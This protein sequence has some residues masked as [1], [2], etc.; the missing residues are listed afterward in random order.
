MKLLRAVQLAFAARAGDEVGV[1]RDLLPR[2]TPRQE[3]H[4][5]REVLELRDHLLYPHHDDVY[6]RNASYQPGVALVGDGA[7]SACLGDPEVGARNAYVRVQEFLRRAVRSTLPGLSPLS[8]AQG[9]RNLLRDGGLTRSPRSPCS[10]IWRGSSPHAAAPEPRRSGPRPRH[11]L[12]RT[13]FRPA[14]R[15]RR[16]SAKGSSRGSP[17]SPV[18]H[19]TPFPS[20]PA[21]RDG[22]STGR[23]V[24]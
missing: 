4:E 15:W 9:P 8:P 13:R 14:P 5:R 11:L 19:D 18:W 22:L 12:R 21:R 16:P 6:G 1:D 17:S 7:D 24:R 20:T 2:P 23:C 10:W 3:L